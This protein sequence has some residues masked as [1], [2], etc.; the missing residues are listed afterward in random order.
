MTEDATTMLRLL[1]LPVVES[2][3]EAEA[4]CATLVKM[5]KCFATATE[6]MDALTF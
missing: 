4:Q 3:C 5:G 1:G 2:P 6:D